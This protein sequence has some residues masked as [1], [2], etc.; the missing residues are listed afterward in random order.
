MLQVLILRTKVGMLFDDAQDDALIATKDKD[1]SLINNVLRIKGGG[2][3]II[4]VHSLV[5][6]CQTYG[7]HARLGTQ[8]PCQHACQRDTPLPL[9]TCA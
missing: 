6:W 9:S 2:R 4:Y 3:R 8:T 5:P 7:T 1:L